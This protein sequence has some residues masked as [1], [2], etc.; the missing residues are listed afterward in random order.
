MHYRGV[1]G[2]NGSVLDES[3]GKSKKFT[4]FSHFSIDKRGIKW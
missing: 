3:Q 2:R 4:D 1:K